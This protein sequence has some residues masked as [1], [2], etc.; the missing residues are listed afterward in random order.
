[1]RVEDVGT[2]GLRIPRV[3]PADIQRIA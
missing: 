2:V 1:L 3:G